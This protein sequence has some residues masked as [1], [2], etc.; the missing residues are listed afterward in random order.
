MV[1]DTLSATS[2]KMRF[3]TG[4]SGVMNSGIKFYAVIKGDFWISV[5]GEKKQYHL[6]TGDCCL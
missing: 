5:D 6:Q 3:K 1:I 2:I 4:Y